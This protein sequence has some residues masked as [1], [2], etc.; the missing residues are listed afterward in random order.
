MIKNDMTSL[1]KKFNIKSEGVATFLNWNRWERDNTNQLIR[2]RCW[3]GNYIEKKKWKHRQ[4]SDAFKFWLSLNSTKPRYKNKNL[5]HK[6][7]RFLV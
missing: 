6:Y 5:W 4:C 2:N 1:N 7:F 3:E